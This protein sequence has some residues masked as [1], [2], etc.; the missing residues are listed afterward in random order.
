MLP[1]VPVLR[2]FVD[3]IPRE[4]VGDEQRGERRESF[5]PLVERVHVVQHAT[6]DD[7]VEL[8]EVGL[9]ERRL[10]VP[11]AGGRVRVDADDVVAAR[12]EQLRRG[13]PRCRSRPR[14]L[15]VAPEAA[16]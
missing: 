11:L 4:L 6:R 8:A 5:E 7:G 14:A 1:L 15:D 12:R 9:F 2:R 10:H 3:Q 16:G 13:R